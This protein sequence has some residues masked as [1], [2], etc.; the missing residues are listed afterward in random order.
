[1]DKRGN[2]YILFLLPF[3]TALAL[4]QAND[5]AKLSV[6]D[7][8]LTASKVDSLA[9]GYFFSVK[10]LPTSGLDASYKP[11][12]RTALAFDDRRQFDMATIE[13]VAQLHNGHT[14]FWDSELD[15]INQPLGFYAA[16]LDGYWV[17]QSSY[18]P[19]LKPGDIIASI[20]TTPTEAFFQQKQRYISAS[21]IAAQRNNLFLFPYLFPEQ[22]TLTLDGG[23]KVAIDRE[24]FKD[25]GQ[26]TD[27]RW[28]KPG[29]TAY[30]R[31]PAFN[32]PRF[33]QGAIDFV[34]Q[35]RRAKAVI[36]DVRS[37]SGG[38]APTRLI[39]ALMDRPYRGW[40]ESTSVRTALAE[41]D[42]KKEKTNKSTTMPAFLQNCE[43]SKGD[44]VCSAS[45]TWGGETVEPSL[46]AFHG[47]VIL[48]ADGGCVSACEDFVEPF[49][50]SGRGTIVG[51]TTQGSSG[52]PY[53]Y[54][55]KNGMSLKIAIKRLYF[56]D[57][58]EFEG[59]GIKPDVEIHPTIESLKSGHDVI[60]QKALDLADKP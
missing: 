12:L 21:S 31:I 28:L 60:Q 8:A 49:K 51:E 40:K 22:F 35:F 57:G 34:R 38:V 46:N 1:M 47:R 42:Q 15:K 52:Q 10:D 33:E 55:F 56:P 48:L 53:F 59:V 9:Q 17:V 43:R 36:I 4:A 11:Y 23:R 54:D 25:P 2:R 41:C 39:Q 18:V 32:N 27:G 30:I 3:V 45:V 7:R 14:F 58:S 44:V 6:E 26:K 50:D 20:D 29:A 37:N 13:F 24:R 19:T 5:S 16:P